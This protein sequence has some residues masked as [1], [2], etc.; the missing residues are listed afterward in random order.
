MVW[1]WHHIRSQRINAKLNAK[2]EP[3]KSLECVSRQ[4]IFCTLSVLFSIIVDNKNVFLTPRTSILKTGSTTPRFCC[5]KLWPT[6]SPSSW[7]REN[8]CM[9]LRWLSFQSES[10]TLQHIYTKVYIKSQ[11]PVKIFSTNV[12]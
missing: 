3:K 6:S 11:H 1:L 9:M 2:F 12:L 7:L 4:C 5:R 8:K 10:D